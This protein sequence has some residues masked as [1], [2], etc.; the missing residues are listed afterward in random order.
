MRHVAQ[1]ARSQPEPLRRGRRCGRRGRAGGEECGRRVRGCWSRR[2]V[3][4]RAAESSDRCRHKKNATHRLFLSLGA[5]EDGDHLGLFAR[6]LEQFPSPLAHVGPPA[7]ELLPLSSGG[8]KHPQVG[9]ILPMRR[10]GNGF[11]GTGRLCGHRGG[12]GGTI[13]RVLFTRWYEQMVISLGWLSPAISC[14][15]PAARTTRAGSRCLFGLAPSGGCRAAP[16]TGRA[17][18]S[19]PTVSPLPFGYKGG[20][21]S[22]A[23]FRRLT[24][25]RRYLAVCPVELGLSSMD[26]YCRS[27]A[28]IGPTTSKGGNYR[29][30]GPRGKALLREAPDQATQTIG[31]GAVEPKPRMLAERHNAQ[32]RPFA[33]RERGAVGLQTEGRE[34]EDVAL[35]IASQQGA[36]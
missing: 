31:R 8:S 12:S 19:Y 9:D 36:P 20:L 35:P 15:L 28:T 11:R 23:L 32:P 10:I 33:L 1:R 2:W 30:T 13:S 5:S 34:R 4:W 17:V 6:H 14:G 18:G 25:P 16:A 24:A 27:T 21:F 26:A 7:D 22:V 3:L 29:A